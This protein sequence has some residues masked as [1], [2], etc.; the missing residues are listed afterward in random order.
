MFCQLPWFFFFIS[1]LNSKNP[2][3]PCYHAAQLLKEILIAGIVVH[4]TQSQQLFCHLQF[5]INTP[6]ENGWMCTV[7]LLCA[8][9]KRHR[10]SSTLQ[11]LFSNVHKCNLI[12][13]VSVL[14]QLLV[15]CQIFFLDTEYE[16][17][18]TRSPSEMALQL[19]AFPLW[20]LVNSPQNFLHLHHQHLSSLYNNPLCSCTAR[21]SSR[22]PHTSPIVL[23]V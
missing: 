14:P 17:I 5:V 9:N 10:V 13:C 22:L 7:G 11:T 20:R 6:D 18:A 21:C 4:G 16:Q 8:F 12:T 1:A 23:R 3:S 19:K 15:L 2:S